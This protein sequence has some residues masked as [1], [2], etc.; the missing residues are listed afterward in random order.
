MT[1]LHLTAGERHP[2]SLKLNG[3]LRSAQ[4]EPRM[5]LCD[6]L[7]HELQSLRRAC[8][9]RARRLRRVHGHGRWAAVRSCTQY[10]V[11]AD[12]ADIVSVEGLAEPGTL[13]NLQR[14]FAKHMPCSAGSARPAF[15]ARR[16]ISSKR[17]RRR[18]KRRCVTCCP[19]TFAAAPAMPQSWRP[20]STQPQTCKRK[21]PDHGPRHR[22]CRLGPAPAAPGSDRRWRSPTQLC[23]M[24]S[25][26]QSGGRRAAADRARARA[27]SRRHHA[28]SLRDGDAL[29]GLP[30]ARRHLH[31]RELARGADEIRYCLEDAEAAAVVSM[32]PPVTRRRRPPLRSQIDPRRVIV[33][34]DGKG[35]GT[36]SRRC[37]TPCRSPGL[38]RRTSSRRA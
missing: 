6:F 19:A 38:R 37:G 30:L 22:L 24:V 34:A 4:A 14:A 28:Q 25:R 8:R 29:L 16:R 33:A 11:Q 7:R 10:A 27:A 18:T 3:Q 21:R 2:V 1:T 17:I 12:G 20:S 35:D 31:A 5:L 26:D 15:Y 32:A 13:N 9:L 36:R 23:A